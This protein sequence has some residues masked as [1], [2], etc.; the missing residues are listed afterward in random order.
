MLYSKNPDGSA[1][2]YHKGVFIPSVPHEVDNRP[3]AHRVSVTRVS[4]LNRRKTQHSR[5]E[6]AAT[7]FTIASLS[8]LEGSEERRCF[9]AG[10][11]LRFFGTNILKV[12]PRGLVVTVTYRL[13]GVLVERESGLISNLGSTSFDFS[14]LSALPVDG[15]GQGSFSV[16]VDWVVPTAEY[17]AL[18]EQELEYYEDLPKRPNPPI[19]T[20][21]ITMFDGGVST[22]RMVTRRSSLEYSLSGWSVDQLYFEDFLSFRSFILAEASVNGQVTSEAR[23]FDNSLSSGG[24]PSNTTFAN[25]RGIF[26]PFSSAGESNQPFRNLGVGSI[27]YEGNVYPVSES[28]SASYNKVAGDHNVSVSVSGLMTSIQEESLFVPMD[29]RFVFFVRKSTATL[30]GF[31]VEEYTVPVVVRLTSSTQTVTIPNT[32]LGSIDTTGVTSIIECVD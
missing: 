5:P 9:K 14:D 11:F 1:N 28:V 25:V 17:N 30:T 6:D 8:V 19:G 27:L 15:T 10:R 29:V 4:G 21:R 20:H 26:S 12:P 3:K 13:E 32:L 7:I 31:D 18:S 23:M 16:R 24:T 22:N 2:Y